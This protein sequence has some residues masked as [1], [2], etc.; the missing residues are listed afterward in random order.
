MTAVPQ[1]LHWTPPRYVVVNH[2]N[3]WRVYDRIGQ[4]PVLAGEYEDCLKYAQRANQQ[5]DLIP[6]PA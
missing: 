2:A 1:G 3:K 4:R 6:R 5:L